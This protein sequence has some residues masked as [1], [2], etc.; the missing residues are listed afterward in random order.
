MCRNVIE[1]YLTDE[2]GVMDT[3]PTITPLTISQLNALK[4]N[5]GGCYGSGPGVLK[6]NAGQLSYTPRWA[7][8]YEFTVIVM[9]G[10]RNSSNTFIIT[11]VPY[12]PPMVDVW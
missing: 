8:S 1:T 12:K 10:Q 4:S 2:N 3:T 11:A 5:K 9:K 6:T 7:G